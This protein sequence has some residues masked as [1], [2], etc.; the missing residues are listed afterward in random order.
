MPGVIGRPRITL[1]D[2][3]GTQVNRQ[4]RRSGINNI[5]EALDKAERDQIIIAQMTDNPDLS[6]DANPNAGGSEFGLD[7]SSNPPTANIEYPTGADRADNLDDFMLEF[8]PRVDSLEAAMTLV[9]PWYTVQYV[10]VAPITQI[11]LPHPVTAAK[12]WRNGLR[13]MEGEEYDFTISGTS[14]LIVGM[15]GDRFIIEYTTSWV[16]S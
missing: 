4:L 9:R 14:V 13:A 3:I 12:V 8:I 16:G 2:A 11:N 10:P 1:H 7:Y 6:P 5:K 15:S